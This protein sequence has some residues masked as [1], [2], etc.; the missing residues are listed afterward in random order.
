MENKSPAYAV[1]F[2][3]GFLAVFAIAFIARFIL[4]K[5][6]KKKKKCAA[7]DERQ[8]AARGKAAFIGFIA[9][10]AWQIFSM[11]MD[12]SFGTLFMTPALWNFC[13]LLVGL[14]AFVITCI[15]KDAY[16]AASEKKLWFFIFTIIATILNVLFFFLNYGAKTAFT[17]DGLLGTPFINLLASFM[18]LIIVINLFAKIQIDKKNYK[19]Q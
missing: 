6:L 15:W 12:I 3:C 18:L 4:V 10:C 17:S 1:G 11:C 2:I 8:I 7:Y 19:E 9:L 13:G 16:F 14:C 5:V